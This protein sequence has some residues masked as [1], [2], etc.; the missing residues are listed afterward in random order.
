[1]DACSLIDQGYS[2]CIRFKDTQKSRFK[3]CFKKQCFHIFKSYCSA[4]ASAAVGGR[5]TDTLQ[6]TDKPA[7]VNP[8]PEAAAS[9]STVTL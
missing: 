2:Q 6:E 4:N 9:V 1:M 5:N 3:C 8:A 7:K